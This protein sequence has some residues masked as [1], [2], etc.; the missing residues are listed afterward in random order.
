MEAAPNMAEAAHV[1]KACAG[2]AVGGAGS[3]VRQE[4]RFASKA[5]RKF[6]LG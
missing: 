3:V 4:G 5:E 6:W 1:G 2:G